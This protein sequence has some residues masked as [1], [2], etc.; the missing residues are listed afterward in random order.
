[1]GQGSF[2]SSSGYRYL[3]GASI[4]APLLLQQSEFVHSFARKGEYKYLCMCMYALATQRLEK[5]RVCGHGHG[6]HQSACVRFKR[7]RGRGCH[8]GLGSDSSH[9]RPYLLCAYNPG[10]LAEQRAYLGVTPVS[11]NLRRS[12]GEKPLVSRH[13]FTRNISGRRQVSDHVITEYC[14]CM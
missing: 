14:T 12:Y 1:M 9:L 4:T 8:P 2:L 5:N 13:I 3:V 10:L 11:L 6:D 7:S